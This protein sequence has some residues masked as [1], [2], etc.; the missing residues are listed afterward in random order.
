[1]RTPY[2]DG[3][4]TVL[5]NNRIDTGIFE[6]NGIMTVRT[7]IPLNFLSSPESCHCQNYVTVRILSPREF[8][9]EFCRI[10][11]DVV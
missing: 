6:I 4:S 5:N 1:M 8:P 7:L 3:I 11:R 2:Q 9:L 10:S